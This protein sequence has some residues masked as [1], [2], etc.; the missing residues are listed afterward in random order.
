[1]SYFIKTCGKKKKIIIIVN[2]VLLLQVYLG[3]PQ[4]SD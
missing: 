4:S 2:S 1:M 3:I